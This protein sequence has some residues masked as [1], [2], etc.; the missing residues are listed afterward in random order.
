VNIGNVKHHRIVRP[1]NISY[2]RVGDMDP[3]SFALHRANYHL[4]RTE[5]YH[6]EEVFELI[7]T[8]HSHG[9]RSLTGF[10][11]KLYW[12]DGVVES[13]SKWK[14]DSLHDPTD[15]AEER[16]PEWAANIAQIEWRYS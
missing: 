12:S 11:G 5:A 4:V 2:P 1:E 6:G 14:E 16:I 13:E 3:E 8:E 15:W 10:D 9:G 7:V